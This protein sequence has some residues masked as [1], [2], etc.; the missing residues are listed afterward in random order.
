MKPSG[1]LHLKLPASEVGR[2][3]T[4]FNVGI[5]IVTHTGIPLMAL[6]CDQLCIDRSYI[7]QRIQTVFV[8]GR[9]IGNRNKAILS[10][11][12]VVALSTAM[13]GLVGCAFHKQG[14]LTDCREDIVDTSL[15]SAQTDRHATVVTLKLFNMVATELGP[16]LLRQQ[17]WVKGHMLR[18][19][20]MALYAPGGMEK[21]TIVW[22]EKV[23]FKD[24]VQKFKWPNA[25]MALHVTYGP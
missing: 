15:E 21:G 16:D 1:S 2:L 8:N 24:E 18:E 22:D 12:A 19:L 17:I 23:F 25:W 10:A 7:D 3:A 6:L 11:N 9:A 20:I 14:P 13:P 5:G 4:I